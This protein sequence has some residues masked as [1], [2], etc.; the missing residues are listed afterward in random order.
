MDAAADAGLQELRHSLGRDLQDAGDVTAG[1]PGLLLQGTGDLPQSRGRVP[2]G[3]VGG[4][5]GLAGGVA[6]AALAPRAGLPEGDH[7]VPGPLR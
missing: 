2:A 6:R 3:P 4:R 7:C 1:Q 5:D